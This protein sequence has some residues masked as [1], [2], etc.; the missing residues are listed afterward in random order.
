MCGN[1]LQFAL[2]MNSFRNVLRDEA[3][4]FGLVWRPCPVV[5]RASS[6]L[7]HQIWD[8][9]FCEEGTCFLVT[10]RLEGVAD[11]FL[12][13]W[14]TPLE[15]PLWLPFWTVHFGHCQKRMP[16]WDTAE[17]PQG[18]GTACDWGDL[19]KLYLQLKALDCWQAPCHEDVGCSSKQAGSAL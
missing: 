14:S 4:P 1:S 15:M 6:V 2:E 19:A 17:A 7:E 9:S 3:S 8:H 18:M 11:P 13:D 16:W 5:H 10:Q 12:R